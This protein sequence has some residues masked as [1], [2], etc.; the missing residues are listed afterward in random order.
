MYKGGRRTKGRGFK[1]DLSREKLM[2]PLSPDVLARQVAVF[3]ET[4]DE[5]A[6]ALIIES[7]IRLALSVV[8]RYVVH[9]PHKSDDL[10]SEALMAVVESVEGAKDNLGPPYNISGWI[11]KSIHNKLSGYLNQ[12]TVVRIPDWLVRKGGTAYFTQLDDQKVDKDAAL[13]V[14]MREQLY[15]MIDRAC[16]PESENEV[17]NKT[18]MGYKQKEIAAS[19]HVS[20]QFVNRLYNQALGKLR[21][22]K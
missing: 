13:K 4:G 8:T 10:V 1:H 12:D 7:H 19:M 2:R 21:S 20:Q 6:K 16:L 15:T 5:E 18:L 22:V 17:I 9:F 3:L 14:Q 11:V